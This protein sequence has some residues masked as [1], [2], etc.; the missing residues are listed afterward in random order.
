MH[1]AAANEDEKETIC[2]NN[3]ANTL[4][5]ILD[6]DKMNNT[7][8]ED[9]EEKLDKINDY[10]IDKE[11][12]A[13]VLINETIDNSLNQTN[14]YKALMDEDQFRLLVDTE[15]KSLYL[16]LKERMNRDD[17]LKLVTER[18]QTNF[19]ATSARRMDNDGKLTGF[20]DEAV[21]DE[22]VDNVLGEVPTDHHKS[23]QSNISS[24]YWGKL[25]TLN[26][27]EQC[28]IMTCSFNAVAMVGVSSLENVTKY[29]RLN[30]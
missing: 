15:P 27:I 5:S 21:I 13:E 24:M 11:L 29:T 18:N 8:L 26:K 3:I 12:Y 20:N 7:R 22:V 25:N 23:D 17:I 2:I 19:L 10:V 28:V 30:L 14:F 16:K 4:V 6:I 1:T 9:L